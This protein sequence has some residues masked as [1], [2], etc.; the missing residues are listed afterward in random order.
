M[1]HNDL[2]REILDVVPIIM[3]VI[4]TEM[5]NQGSLDLSIPQFRTLLYISRNPGTPLLTLA[6]HLGLSSPTVSK[7]VDGLVINRLISRELSSKDRRKITLSLTAQG[8]DILERARNESQARLTMVLS[9]L[10]PEENE[11][12]FRA[13]Q[14]LKPLF[15][16]D[17]VSLQ[18]ESEGK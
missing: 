13:I 7:M 12:V 5:R 10:S 15:L 1:S 2:A 14:L 4:R 18:I 16:L 11:T 3:R 6:D 9:R 8:Q 17:S